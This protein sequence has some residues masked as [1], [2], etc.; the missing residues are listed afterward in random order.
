MLLYAF[1]LDLCY[2]CD[3]FVIVVI[4]ILSLL[5]FLVSPAII[6]II[7]GDFFMDMTHPYHRVYSYVFLFCR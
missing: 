4:T 5:L 6:G 2:R 1:L 3:Y 7:L